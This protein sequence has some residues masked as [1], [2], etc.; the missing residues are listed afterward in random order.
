MV[1]RLGAL[2]ARPN[3]E[4]SI[5]DKKLAR[6]FTDDQEC[7]R[8]YGSEQGKKLRI[9]LTT[10]QAAVSLADLWPPNRGPERCHELT[11]DKAGIFSIDLK[12]PYRLLLRQISDATKEQ[13]P[14]ERERWERIT[15]IE[16][17]GI[18]DTHA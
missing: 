2:G 10:L 8:R 4:I 3:M 16:I 12:H 17:I 18:E 6:A 1:K 15:S 7:V 5:A 9:R 14:N 11:G 13:Y